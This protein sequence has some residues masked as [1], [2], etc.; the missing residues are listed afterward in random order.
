MQPTPRKTFVR[1]W[2]NDWWLH[3][4]SYALYMIREL[5]C[6]ALALYSGVVIYGLGRLSQGPEAWEGFVLALRSPGFV[7]FHLAALV[8]MLYHTVTWFQLTPKAMP[9]MRGPEFLPG[10]FIIGAH[11]AVW[12]VVSLVVLIIAGV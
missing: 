1:P 9:I 3:K 11:Y 4:R 2:R 10:R 12:A 8:L 5:T 6:I 7:T